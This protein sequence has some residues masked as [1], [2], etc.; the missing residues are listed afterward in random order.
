MILAKKTQVAEGTF[1]MKSSVEEKKML[2]TGG[3]NAPPPFAD[4]SAAN[5]F[6]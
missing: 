3:Y 4:M 5:R 1:C 6:I 2:Q